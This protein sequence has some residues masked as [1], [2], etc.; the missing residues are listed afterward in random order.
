MAGVGEQ[1]EAAGTESGN[2][3]KDRKRQRRDERSV[4]NPACPVMVVMMP[5]RRRSCFHCTTNRRFWRLLRRHAATFPPLSYSGDGGVDRA[6][7]VDFEVGAGVC[8][9][10]SYLIRVQR[11]TNALFALSFSRA[12]RATNALF[13]P[14]CCAALAAQAK[15]VVE[16]GAEAAV[17]CH[18]LAH[19]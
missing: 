17:V 10:N 12:Q 9:T 1:R 11:A 7:D 15:Q 14:D 18:L 4:K 3:F 19:I 5:Q 16:A 6:A 2:D 8:E 13:A